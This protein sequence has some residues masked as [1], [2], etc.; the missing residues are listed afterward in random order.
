MADLELN[1]KLSDALLKS[2]QNLQISMERYSSILDKVVGKFEDIKDYEEDINVK[3]EKGHKLL[4][5]KIFATVKDIGKELLAIAKQPL[6]KL[7]SAAYLI[8]LVKKTMEHVGAIRNLSYRM[9]EAGKTSKQLSDA[10]FSVAN[11]LGISTDASLEL[12]AGLSRLRVPTKDLKEMGTITG[13]F[14]RV[15]GVSNEEA[16][17][18][19]ANLMRMGNLGAKATKSVLTGM[20]QMQ[21]Q[22]G[23]TETDMGL[24]TDSIT[25]STRMLGQM[26]KSAG[27]IERFNK[28]VIGLAAGFTKV[29]IS[30][31]KVQDLVDRLLDPGNIE[32]NALLYA[33]LGV[34]IQDVIS[35]NVDLD[36]LHAKMRSFGQD[37]KNMSGPAAADL[38]KGMHMTLMNARALADLPIDE[39][40]T[41]AGKSAKAMFE[42]T[43]NIQ[44]KFMA[45]WNRI[46]TTVEKV[47]TPILNWIENFLSRPGALKMLALA[48]VGL[49]IL[50]VALLRRK[51]LAVATDFGKTIGTATTE[52]LIMAEHKAQAVASARSGMRGRGAVAGLTARVTAG[53]GFAQAKE[54]ANIFQTLAQ[55]NVFPAVARMTQNTAEWYNHVAMGQKPISM[56]GIKVEQQNAKLKDRIGFVRQEQTILNETYG[57]QG[58][59]LS[60]QRAVYDTRRDSLR[61]MIE[62]GKVLTGEQNWELKRLEGRKYGNRLLRQETGLANEIDA[63]NKRSESR[64]INSLT[65]MQPEALKLMNREL[66]ARE[67]VL[68][69]SVAISNQRIKELQLVGE[70]SIKEK[71]AMNLQKAEAVAKGEYENYTKIAKKLQ[72]IDNE[73]KLR[74]T[75]LGEINTLLNTQLK[76]A[77]NIAHQMEN[78][79]AATKK[80]GINLEGVDI[81]KVLVSKGQRFKQFIV[82]SFHAAG[83]GVAST[84]AKVGDS[85]R[86]VGKD[87][88]ARLNPA[89]MLRGMVGRNREEAA[90]GGGGKSLMGSLGK[91]AMIATMVLTTLGLMEPIQKVIGTILNAF[92]PLISKL[93]AI[94]LPIIMNLIKALLPL[95]EV[96]IKLL[97]PPLLKILGLVFQ[98]LGYLIKGIAAFI[99]IFPGGGGVADMVEGLSREFIKGGKDIFDASKLKISLDKNTNALD[100]L[101]SPQAGEIKA[102]GGIASVRTGATTA[103]DIY[104][105]TLANER[106]AAKEKREALRLEV[107]RKRDEVMIQALQ[108]IEKNTATTALKTVSTGKGNFQVQVTA[109][110]KAGT[111]DLGIAGGGKSR[112]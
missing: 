54:T 90:G 44:D 58:K 102:I 94:F 25:Q 36:Q 96:L 48:A 12:V 73:D 33:K 77:G 76:E 65:R 95:M 4:K 16:I 50:V 1:Q 80:T 34:S 108:N 100:K 86:L 23:L 66:K 51:M 8:D 88:A 59:S 106:E 89:N 24:L 107:Q 105:Q 18:L 45:V 110:A 40:M 52:A 67:Q 26:G 64:Q 7:F 111:L 27:D 87:L 14:A 22:V 75:E 19:T 11:N 74:A 3:F 84:F 104:A 91:L 49:I 2:S 81:D 53:P 39:G 47:L 37:M 30:I 109:V 9:G 15:T 83:Q 32:E 60:T 63:I 93:I 55:S 17:N 31:D 68:D 99:R 56:M 42:E 20:M 70:I 72:E 78:I 61:A 57:I 35:G 71:A 41:K 98:G 112:K 97:L 69:A 10:M 101:T 5:D 85:L 28:G 43:R 6:A 79:A 62:E 103:K 29:G 38:A 21:R 13:Q 82:G 46:S 92:K